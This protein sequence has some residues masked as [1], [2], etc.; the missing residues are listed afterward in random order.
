MAVQVYYLMLDQIGEFITYMTNFDFGKFL[1]D[2][3]RQAGWD[4]IVAAHRC[5]ISRWKLGRIERGEAQPDFQEVNQILA[6]FN[7][8]T[9]DLNGE[10]QSSESLTIPDCL[11]KIEFYFN[12]LRRM[13][14][15]R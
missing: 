6:A 8:P 1:R 9:I 7:K 2:N 13:I 11:H 10:M 5:G 3:R 12:E 14:S 4:Q 15:G